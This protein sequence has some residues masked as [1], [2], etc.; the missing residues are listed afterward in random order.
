MFSRFNLDT[1]YDNY[2]VMGNPISHSLSPQIHAAFAE[3]TGQ[4]LHYQAI[5][6]ESGEFAEAV[7]RFYKAGGKGI[8]V[9]IPFKQEAWAL[10]E[11]RSQ[12]AELAGAVNTLGFDQAGCH[13]GDNTDGIGFVRDYLNNHGGSIKGR[14]ILVLGAGGAV[15]GALGPILEEHPAQLAIANRTLAKASELRDLFAKQGEIKVYAYEDLALHRFDLIINGTAASLEGQ[16]PPLPEANLAQGSHCYD[17]MYAP[18]PTPFIQWGYAHGAVRSIDGL[19][20]LVEQAAEAF[21]LWRDVK[22]DTQPVIERLRNRV[23]SEIPKSNPP[24]KEGD[25]R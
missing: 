13:Y 23:A 15:R 9:T 1:R 14:R 22:P 5:R 7:E 20:M 19:G 17:M 4:R 3:Q 11:K 24:L 16:L 2:C 6:V 18:E 21:F 12:R 25:Q 10:V 8:N